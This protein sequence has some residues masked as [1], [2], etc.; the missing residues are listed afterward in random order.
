MHKIDSNPTPKNWT[1]YYRDGLPIIG[2]ASVSM[3]YMEED[4][5][6]ERVC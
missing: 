1:L 4:E 6:L 5:I 3:R 2:Q